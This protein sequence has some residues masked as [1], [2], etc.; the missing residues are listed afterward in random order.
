MATSPFA[1]A[2]RAVQR[3]G[4]LLVFPLENRTDLPSVWS[5]LHPGAAM[6]WDWD[7]G[8]D[9]RVFALWQ[10]RAKMMTSRKVVYAKWFRGRATVFAPDVFTAM[11]CAVR[12][13]R[14]PR[15]GLLPEAAAILEVLDENSPVSSKTLR[16]LVDLQGKFHERAWTKAMAQLW[17]RLLVVG[18]GEVDDGAFPSLAIGSTALLF[19]ELWD[20]SG[21][22]LPSEARATLAARLGEDGAFLPYFE[23]TLTAL[24]R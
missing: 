13:A 7:D 6:R 17:A 14:D 9:P 2:V 4:A 12:D 19:E 20:A 15:K 11:L 22:T 24:R 3:D 8:G 21:G 10:L 16:G 1:A 23:K 5:R 18:Y